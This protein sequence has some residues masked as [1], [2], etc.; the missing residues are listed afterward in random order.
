ML[1]INKQWV[2]FT[3]F[4]LSAYRST[5][6]QHVKSER[7]DATVVGFVYFYLKFIVNETKDESGVNFFGFC[8]VSRRFFPLSESY[9]RALFSYD[10]MLVQTDI[11]LT[12]KDTYCCLFDIY[13]E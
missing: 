2:I 3:R 7:I 4:S 13:R 11:F 5:E 1:K 12:K 10:A 8:P 6:N 9:L